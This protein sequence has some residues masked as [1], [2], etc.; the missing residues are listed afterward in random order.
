MT[1]VS[2]TWLR[3]YDAIQ[4]A[5]SGSALRG[6]W[7]PLPAVR[8]ARVALAVVLALCLSSCE[9]AGAP[10]P[11]SQY[12]QALPGEWQGSVG[13]AQE[14]IHLAADGSFRAQVQSGGFIGTTLGQGSAG[15]LRGSW[16][17]QGASITL[18]VDQA[19][20]ERPADSSTT[21]T[22]VSFNQNQLVL[23]DAA[24][25]LTTFDRAL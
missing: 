24:G 9:R 5:G 11:Q 12:A 17:L 15:T 3:R 25:A 22:I 1:S 13:G 6:P 23:E 8:I 4:C 14:S 16:T 7:L 19:S 2:A 10:L 20:G 21:S 18:A